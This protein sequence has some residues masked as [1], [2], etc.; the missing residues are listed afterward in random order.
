MMMTNEEIVR[1]FRQAKFPPKQ[2]SIIADQNQCTRREIAEILLAAGENVPR[3]FLP[4]QP[5]PE[6]EPEPSLPPA[7]EGAGEYQ[8][9]NEKEEKSMEERIARAAVDAIARCLKESDQTATS[10][11]AALD[12]REQVRGVLCV[13]KEIMD[14][15]QE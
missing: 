5:K 10:E 15:A 9:E 11:A 8:D 6:P 4:R 2:I 1:E 13:T 14:G 3:Q 7:P 12:F